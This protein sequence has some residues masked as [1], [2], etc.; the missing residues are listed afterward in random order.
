MQAASG[1]VQAIR[2]WNNTYRGRRRHNADSTVV[3]GNTL[4]DNI[5]YGIHV[6]SGQKVQITGNAVRENTD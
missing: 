4:F 5:A 6:F 1:K 3:T 2:A